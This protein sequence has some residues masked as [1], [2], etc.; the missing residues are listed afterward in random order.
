MKYA[1]IT[2]NSTVTVGTGK[3]VLTSKVIDY[4]L[5][6]A[7]PHE[8]IVYYYCRRGNEYEDPDNVIR[9]LFR[10]LATPAQAS[11]SI[12]KDVDTLFKQTKDKA[13][14]LPIEV[15]K[16]ELPKSL[17]QYGRV[18]FVIDALDE[19]KVRARLMDTVDTLLS[20]TK[21]PTRV[22]VSGRADVDIKKR[23][24]KWP[25]I[26]T[27]TPSSGTRKDIESFIDQK[28]EE[29]SCWQD[30]SEEE[31]REIRKKL[32]AKSNGM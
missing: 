30:M 2:A 18:T 25:S 15:C 10:Q 27:D 13:S 5:D 24:S 20:C 16:Q 7:H 6:K 17:D 8:R 29:F 9:S 19:C 4:L 14:Q 1:S 32:L 21:T 22:F 28:V 23:F 26:Q 11:N 3:T 31:Q 12:R